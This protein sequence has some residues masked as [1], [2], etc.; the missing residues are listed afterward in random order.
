MP[1]RSSWIS[2]S[3]EPIRGF[4][5]LSIEAHVTQPPIGVGNTSAKALPANLLPSTHLVPTLPCLP[6]C[7]S[8]EYSEPKHS[9]RL[10]V[11]PGAFDGSAASKTSYNYT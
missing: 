10:S 3:V 7:W 5:S 1:M 8:D 9:R 11:L 4:C 6:A 2:T